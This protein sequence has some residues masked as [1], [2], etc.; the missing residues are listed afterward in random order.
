MKS[1]SQ[2]I[3]NTV[4]ADRRKQK[5]DMGAIN[6]PQ[7]IVDRDIRPLFEL[8][9]EIHRT[10]NRNLHILAPVSSNMGPQSD[11]NIGGREVKVEKFPHSF[12]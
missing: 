9:R 3:P 11:E 8:M 4:W 2:C 12:V 1:L 6:K 5:D 7:S 10:K